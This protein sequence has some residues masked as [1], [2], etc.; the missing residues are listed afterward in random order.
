MMKNLIISQSPE[1]ER[2]II[3]IER[4]KSII[5]NLIHALNDYHEAT[6]LTLIEIDDLTLSSLIEHSSIIPNRDKGLG[7]RID[8]VNDCELLIDL[9]KEK[10][11]EFHK[12]KIGGLPVQREVFL[13]SVEVS[14]DIIES[15][16]D[17]KRE[18]DNLDRD[19]PSDY[20][21]FVTVKKGKLSI[22][23]NAV[24]ELTNKFTLYAS[25]VQA[26]AFDEINQAIS[27]LRELESKYRA[28]GLI[29]HSIDFEPSHL[30]Q[31]KLKDL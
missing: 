12:G 13:E 18:L 22:A 11:F 28:P 8:F 21:Q 27:R 4:C 30:S 1:L 25:Q 20:R 3:A 31:I 10:L 2:N 15:L 19:T 16:V 26:Q 24:E 23:A 7:F 14:R 6:N 29:T 9:T 17:A 5:H